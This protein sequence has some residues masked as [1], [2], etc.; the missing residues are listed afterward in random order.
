MTDQQ[1]AKKVE[2]ENK[3]KNLTEVEHKLLKAL[4]NLRD[5]EAAGTKIPESRK[6]VEKAEKIGRAHV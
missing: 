6:A 3:Q 1:N 4:G 5:S 2:L